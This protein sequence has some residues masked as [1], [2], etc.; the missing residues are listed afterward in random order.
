VG[1]LSTKMMLGE[2]GARG[3]SCGRPV[4]GWMPCVKLAVSVHKIFPSTY[5]ARL[6]EQIQCLST[7]TPRQSGHRKPLVIVVCGAD[8]SG[9]FGDLPWAVKP[10]MAWGDG[11]GARWVLQAQG[12]SVWPACTYNASC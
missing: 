12:T 5:W 1:T 8:P 10:G 4:H 9:P 6:G 2:H 7:Q 11:D 3:W